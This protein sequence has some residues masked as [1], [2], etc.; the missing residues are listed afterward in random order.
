MRWSQP[1]VE[2]RFTLSPVVEK[3]LVCPAQRG[4]E[5]KLIYVSGERSHEDECN[6]VWIAGFRF[7]ETLIETF[8][9]YRLILNCHRF[10]S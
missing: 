6:P 5:P 3:T 8:H 1:A 9:L 4:A 10:T 7:F 2:P